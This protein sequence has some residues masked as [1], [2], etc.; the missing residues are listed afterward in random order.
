MSLQVIAR[1]YLFKNSNNATS[2]STFEI[3]QWISGVK[4]SNDPRFR[5]YSTTSPIIETSYN[6]TC[7]AK[8]STWYLSPKTLEVDSSLRPIFSDRFLP[9]QIPLAMCM[10]RK[11]MNL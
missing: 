6:Q 5:N 4:K 9:L 2:S 11:K 1:N 10:I 3:P 7:T 8:L